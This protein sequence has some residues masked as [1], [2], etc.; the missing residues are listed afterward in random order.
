MGVKT[1]EW[2]SSQR[3]DPY[4][5][6]RPPFGP[7]DP[8]VNGTV[9]Q[10]QVRSL[11]IDKY[12]TFF[13][14]T[15]MGLPRRDHGKSRGT[16]PPPL[17]LAEVFWCFFSVKYP[18]RSVFCIY[19]T[20]KT[21]I[22]LHKHKLRGTPAPLDPRRPL[23]RYFGGFQCL[24]YIY[25]LHEKLVF[26]HRNLSSVVERSAPDQAVRVRVRPL[27]KKIANFFL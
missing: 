24:Y 23:P 27:P 7:R 25:K 2:E 22:N 9:P 16:P 13:F 21:F 15:H 18:F 10:K 26:Q 4:P 1:L 19:I 12:T 8:P 11:Y 3:R 5:M 20:Y 17:P 14:E 6:S